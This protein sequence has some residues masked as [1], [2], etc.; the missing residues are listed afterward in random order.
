MSTNTLFPALVAAG[1]LTA[2]FSAMA[3]TKV[4]Y[5]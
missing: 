3:A 1:I 2:P 5:R 4:T